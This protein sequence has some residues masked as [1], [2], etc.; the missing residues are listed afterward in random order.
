M[1][2]IRHSLS[3]MML[4]AVAPLCSAAAQQAAMVYRLGR[5]TV[6]IEQFTRSGN[7]LSGEVV[8]RA[9]AAV[10]RLQY[11]IALADGRATS[12]TVRRRQADGT[13]MANAPIEWRFTFTRDSAKRD[14]VWTDSM[15]TRAFA[16]AS[17]VLLLPVPAFAHTELL[18]IGMRRPGVMADSMIGLGIA[19]NPSR[20]GLA[21]A[22]GDTL[23]LVGGSYPMLV[24][25]D[26]EG[27]LLSLDGSQTTNKIL[28]MRG[29]GGLDIAAIAQR[30]TPT[31]VLSARGT[32]RATVR[33]GGI[34]M[35]DYGRPMVRERTVWGGTLVPFDSVWRTGANDATHLATSRDIAFGDVVV[36]AGV[37][38][39]W[40][41]HTRNG[42]TLLIS[43]QVGV[44][45]TAFDAAQVLGRVP[46]T[47]TASPEHVEEFTITVRS[48]GMSRGALDLAWGPSV[49]TAMFIMR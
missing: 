31:G 33:Q 41:Q 24:R 9:G 18:A 8:T 49:A 37:Y 7:R 43:R 1:L 35:V 13:P 40:V 27:R 30:M 47:L 36:P 15:Q 23:R 10:T 25:F 42:T 4:A 38:T 29:A 21:R 19:G 26:A 5:D 32:A 48:L 14:I 6:A 11:D 28:G 16:A 12:A 17:A 2:T 3:L 22:G 46:L 44:W 34:V 45:G 39:L 20:A